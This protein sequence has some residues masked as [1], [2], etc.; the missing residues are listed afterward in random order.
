MDELSITEIHEL[1]IS[2]A[3][4][5]IQRLGWKNLSVTPLHNKQKQQLAAGVANSVLN[6]KWAMERYRSN[7]VDSILGL[8]VKVNHHADQDILHAVILCK[9]DSRRLLFSLCMLENFVQRQEP[10][11]SGKILKIALIYST[12]FCEIIG[13]EEMYIQD[14]T[15]EVRPRYTAYSFAQVWHDHDKISADVAD[16]LQCL[17][18]KLAHT[19]LIV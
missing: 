12:F 1:C 6:W 11:L 8:S 3:N 4:Q 7:F 5:V 2:M 19:A 14:P 13:L 10:A 18:V 16:V 15:T 9:Y 17:R